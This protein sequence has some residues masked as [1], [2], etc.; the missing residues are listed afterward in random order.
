MLTLNSCTEN[1][2]ESSWDVDLLAPILTTSLDIG[3]LIPDSLTQADAEGRLR[4]LIER[5]LI[6]LNIDSIFKL[7]DT[8]IAQGLVLPV[9][10]T[11]VAPGTVIPVLP[12][13]TKYNLGEVQLKHV[14]VRQGRLRVRLRNRLATD[15]DFTYSIAGAVRWGQP[16]VLN[17]R[18]PAG[19]SNAQY[20]EFAYDL[21]WYDIDLRGPSGFSSNTINATYQLKTALDG[22]TVSHPANDTLFN[23]EYSFEG[24]VPHYVR[25]YFGQKGA[26]AQAQNSDIDI[27]R[28]ITSGQMLLDSVTIALDIENGVGADGQFRLDALRSIN[29]RTGTTLDLNHPPL[30]GQSIQFMRATD[31]DGSPQGVAAQKYSYLLNNA[32]SNIKQFIENLPDRLEFTFNLGLNPM[33]NVSSS[34]DFFYYDRP[35]RAMM[36]IDVPLRAQMND[37]T[38]VDTLDWDLGSQGAVQSINSTD[39]NIRVRNG[40]PF[41]AQPLLTLLDSLGAPVAQ[42]LA[43]GMVEAPS[44]NASGKVTA[45][46]E[47]VVPLIITPEVSRLLPLTRKIE[48]RMVF[49]TTDQPNLVQ[50]YE[51]YT[52]DLKIFG[53]FNYT[54]GG[55]GL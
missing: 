15:V 23:I 7:P 45:P 33:G 34:K 10:L 30:I 5:P 20:V 22:Q 21:S 29:S 47:S 13:V 40:F 1:L 37:L 19:N 43:G 28:R 49:N 53:R 9:P 39:L 26:S 51:G 3:D 6:D 2:N 27:L 32:T 55:S 52:L 48:I 8:T 42:L 24:L 25:G 4:L 11:N 17:E 35:F 12:S 36:R 16:L 38:L 14:T 31:T 46:L 54:F 41:R 44:L 50:L 18:I